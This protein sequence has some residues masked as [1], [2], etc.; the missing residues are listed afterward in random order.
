MDRTTKLTRL[1]SGQIKPGPIVTLTVL[2]LATLCGAFGIAGSAIA[3]DEVVAAKPSGQWKTYRNARYGVSVNYPESVF[4]R[5]ES[6]PDNNAGRMF[7][8]AQGVSFSVYSVA[9]ALL[10]EPRVLLK[11][12]AAEVPEGAILSKLLR[13]DGFDLLYSIRG[14]EEYVA[15]RTSDQGNVLHWLNIAWPVS[16]AEAMRPVAETMAASLHAEVTASTSGRATQGGVDAFSYKRIASRTYSF[17]V[18]GVA[19][20]PSFFV[21]IPKF[22]IVEEE[23]K[24]DN[25]VVFKSPDEDPDATIYLAFKGSSANA[26]TAKAHATLHALTLQ[27]MG[28]GKVVAEQAF[29]FNG[30]PAYRI[31]QEMMSAHDSGSQL[32]DEVAVIQQDDVLL[33]INLTAPKPIWHTASQ[34]MEQALATLA[35]A[36]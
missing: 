29:E 15:L 5:K 11:D 25:E 4:T 20:D 12:A 34:A 21:E 16:L 7:I 24:N 32:V 13:D 23:A 8:G 14:A 6:A 3:K 22:F 2:L 19:A 33:A 9:N 26:N 28:G 27:E 10:Q 36:P 17:N 30:R 18:H 1:P 35:F 31:R